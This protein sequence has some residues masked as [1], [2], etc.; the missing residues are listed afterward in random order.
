MSWLFWRKPRPAPSRHHADPARLPGE[1]QALPSQDTSAAI[2]ELSRVVQNNP[3]SIEIY[4]A[5]GNLYRS[6][7]EVERAVQIRNNLIVRPGLD[8]RFKAKALYELGRDYKRAGFLDRARA[9]LEEAQS[10]SGRDNL[11]LGELAR[12]AADS[13]DYTQA[14]KL[15]A[16]LNH[17]LAE[18]HYLV[19]LAQESFTHGRDVQGRKAL[20]KALDVYPGSLEAWLARLTR[21]YDAEEKN[22]L[23]KTLSDALSKVRSGLSFVLLEGL[24]GHATKGKLT[25]SIEAGSAS[26]SH[27]ESELLIA[28]LDELES[29]SSELLL[30]YYGALILALCGRRQEANTWLEKT[31]LLDPNFWP[32]RLDLLALSQAD[33]NLSPLFRNQLEFFVSKARSVKRFACG[34]CGLRQ[35]QVFFVCARCGSWHSI[36]FRMLLTD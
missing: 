10:L 26:L 32:A 11:I 18:A 13:G 22:K 31:L 15:Y 30:H 24:L 14:S 35:S 34:V 16:Q 4:L 7:G 12:L 19:K 5:L 21:D 2:G 17:P 20:T 3:D 9:A 23:R 6:Q 1:G 8:K 36:A 29:R 27:S 25:D 33:Q 28:V